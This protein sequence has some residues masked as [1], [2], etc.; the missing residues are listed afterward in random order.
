MCMVIDLNCNTA[1]YFL[2]KTWGKAHERFTEMTA[3]DLDKTKLYS[4][5]A[6]NAFSV[7]TDRQVCYTEEEEEKEK[8]EATYLCAKRISCFAGMF[9]GFLSQ[10]TPPF[11]SLFCATG[12]VDHGARDWSGN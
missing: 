10:N 6:Q 5:L 7:V 12:R 11:L 8:V 4:C 3:F 9:T 2:N 1:F